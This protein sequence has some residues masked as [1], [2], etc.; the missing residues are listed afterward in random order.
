MNERDPATDLWRLIGGYQVSQAIYVAAVLGIPDRL[1]GGPRPCI[2]L[3]QETDS[4]PR[5]L[6]RLMRALAAVGVFREEPGQHF[7]L[8]PLAEYLTS[9]TN[10]PIGPYAVFS[11]SRFVWQAWG[12]LLHSVKTGDNAFRQRHGTDIWAYTSEHPADGAIFDRAMT[13]LSRG[14]A[15][16]VVAA[17]DWSFGCIVD[18]GGGQGALLAGILTSQPAA[19]GVLFDLPHVVARSSE[20]LRK[21]GLAER[22]KIV[23]GSFFDEI[24]PDGNAYVLKV[25]LHD[26]EDD[27]AITILK[28]CRRVM[29][30]TSRLLVIE[31]LIGPANEMPEA[32]FSDLN[33]MVLPGGLERTEAEF[34]ALFSA[35]GFQLSGVFPT[36][37]RLNL[38]EGQPT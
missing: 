22:C 11:G 23:A 13:A 30:G 24:P 16:A 38:I 36:G 5:A 20:L 19:R 29:S 21:A 1:K 15:E 2:A 26:W 3:A 4:H 32:K 28:N 34:A 31:R 8:T 9:D 7:S 35:A 25:I 14:A 33:M 27:E 10:L 17:Y 6:Y 18:V 12:E 37:T